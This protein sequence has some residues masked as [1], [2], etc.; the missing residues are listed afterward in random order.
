MGSKAKALL[1][2]VA[3]GEATNELI[4]VLNYTLEAGEQ[5]LLD[6]QFFVGHTWM[7]FQVN[8]QRGRASEVWLSCRRG[9][10]AALRSSWLSNLEYVPGAIMHLIFLG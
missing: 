9:T 1:V 4:V 8:K 2:D 7:A 6:L 5:R 10:S 3:Q